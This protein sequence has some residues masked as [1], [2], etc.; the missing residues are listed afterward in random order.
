[1]VQHR[2]FAEALSSLGNAD[3]VLIIGLDIDKLKRVEQAVS[4]YRKGGRLA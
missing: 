3:K 2:A 1:M 4:R